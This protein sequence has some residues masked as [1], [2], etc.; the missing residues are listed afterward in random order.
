LKF[1]LVIFK[2]DNFIIFI[3][4]CIYVL[5]KPLTKETI[6]FM[7]IPTLFVKDSFEP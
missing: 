6:N 7:I 3:I 4:S 2:I 5:V 1:E